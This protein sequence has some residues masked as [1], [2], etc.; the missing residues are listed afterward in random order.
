MHLYCENGKVQWRSD[1]D[2]DEFCIILGG[3][4]IKLNKFSS[5]YS[6]GKVILMTDYV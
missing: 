5:M 6:V 3:S 1:N 2:D 4:I